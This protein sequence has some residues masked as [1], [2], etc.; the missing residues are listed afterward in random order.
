MSIHPS[1]NRQDF[2]K[3]PLSILMLIFIWNSCWSQ[4]RFELTHIPEI[5][6]KRDITLVAE[7]GFW[8]EHLVKVLLPKFTQHTSVNVK[9]VAMPLVDM[10]QLQ[11]QSLISGQSNYDLLAI[12]AGWAKEWAA[13]G[14][15]VPLLELAKKY[16]DKG[17]QGMKDLLE[18][19]YPSLLQILAYQ[20]QYHSVPYNNYVMGQHYRLDLFENAHEK[21]KFKDTYGYALTAPKN[22]DQLFD[23]AQFFTRKKGENLAGR[24]LKH[25]F[26]GLALMSGHRPHINDEF[27]AML[28]GLGGK[29]FEPVYENS[30]KVKYFEV[31]ANS[32][33]ALKVA[34]TYLK[35][36][37]YSHPAHDQWAYLESANALA[38]GHV[39][40]WP[41]AYNNLW[42]ISAKFE[43]NIPYAQ[44]GIA[45]V[46]LQRP[47]NGAYATAVSFSSLNPEAAYWLLKYI[48]SYEGQMAYALGGGL[49][50]RK[51]VVMADFFQDKKQHRLSGA[52]QASH[53][54]NLL[55][56]DKVLDLGHFNSTAMGKIYPELMNTTF[57]IRSGA[58]K[59]KQA[60]DQLNSKIL[61]LQN[62]YG[63][64]AAVK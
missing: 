11:T 36:L 37:P 6:N 50:C 27:S 19:Y 9:V 54:A 39:A 13:N 2:W 1:F 45:Q 32:P 59:P 10:Y 8:T 47:Y 29:W 49:P 56:T 35:L 17:E 41:F 42:A 64:A 12:E 57:Q 48:G 44:I 40:I 4:Q 34:Q 15:T 60:L 46:P 38:Q 20:G 23:V 18:S 58:L 43:K 14:Y 24:K 26:Y 61:E 3:K 52:F 31:Q 16:D 22:L 62:R 21:K 55:W 5:S 51:D 33:T 63:E 28:W 25:D 30:K 53:Q 7:K